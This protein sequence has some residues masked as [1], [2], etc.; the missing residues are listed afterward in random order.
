MRE[1]D[2]KIDVEKRKKLSLAGK[3]NTQFNQTKINNLNTPDKLENHVQEKFK[4]EKSEITKIMAGLDEEISKTNNYI[5]KY[6]MKCTFLHYILTLI[7]QF[8]F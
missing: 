5:I 8:S 4:R 6:R 2:E 3:F 7:L 1:L